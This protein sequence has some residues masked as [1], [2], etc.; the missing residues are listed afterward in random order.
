MFRDIRP[1][2]MAVSALAATL[3]SLWLYFA[4]H[5]GVDGTLGAGL[6]LFASACLLAATFI[7]GMYRLRSRAVF[8]TFAILSL[9]AVVCTMLAGWFLESLPLVILIGFFGIVLIWWLTRVGMTGS[10]VQI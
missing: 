9:I 8:A 7:M 5:N 1:M 2:L 10:K 6:V 4:A 3:L